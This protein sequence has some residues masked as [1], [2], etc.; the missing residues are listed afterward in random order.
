QVEH[1]VI[2]EQFRSLPVNGP[3][4][5]DEHR[6]ATFDAPCPYLN[7]FVTAEDKI[8]PGLPDAQGGG[9]LCEAIHLKTSIFREH[10]A[11]QGGGT[12]LR[13]CKARPLFADWRAAREG[14][15]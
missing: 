1:I 8:N 6:A 12:H 14:I 10:S 15:E 2:A 9:N 3:R 13:T 11:A 7:R 5:M 4:D